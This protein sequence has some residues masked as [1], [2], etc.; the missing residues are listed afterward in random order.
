M[1]AGSL[2]LVVE[3][4]PA[5]SSGLLLSPLTICTTSSS[6]SVCF[7][8]TRC[9][10]CLVL[11]PHTCA[12]LSCLANA[13]LIWLQ[14]CF[15]LH[16]PRWSASTTGSTKSGLFPVF[17]VYTRTSPMESHMRRSRGSYP[18]SRKQLMHTLSGR[19]L[20]L[21]TSS[22][23]STSTLLYT[24]RHLMY[25]RFPSSASISWSTVQ[26][27]LNSSSQWWILYSAST[28]RM[29]LSVILVSPP[30]TVLLIWVPPW[31]LGLM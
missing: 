8:P 17:L 5:K 2:R 15:T 24:Y 19:L 4:R 28:L 9:P 18:S 29:V 13:V 23:V 26:S 30:A 16:P 1:R 12:Y 11:V 22:M 21:S 7:T 31:C 6:C 20:R 3:K 14:N 25:L 27:S 10:M